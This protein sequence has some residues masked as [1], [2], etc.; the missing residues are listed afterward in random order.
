M[1]DDARAKGA[2]VETVAP[3][4]ESLPDRATR[5]IA[6]TIVRDV[7]EDMRIAHEE[8]FGPVL[9]VRPYSELT[10]VIDHINQR[11]APLVAF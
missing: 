6:P 10:D 11:P 9:V 3:A 4:G 5:K 1:I 8:V 2:R 7:V